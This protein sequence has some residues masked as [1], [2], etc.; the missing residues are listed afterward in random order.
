MNEIIFLVEHDVEEGYVAQAL[1]VSIITQADNLDMLKL[2]VRDAV[3][4]HF[5]N[6]ELRPKIIR[7][8]IVKEEV[9]AS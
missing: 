4:C 6:E 5:P 8:H 7:L 1:G 2:E 3:S 9:I